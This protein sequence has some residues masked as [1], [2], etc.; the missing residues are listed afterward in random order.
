[1]GLTDIL[2]AA[3]VASHLLGQL[4]FQLQ[5]AQLADIEEGAILGCL[6]KGTFEKQSEKAHGKQILLVA[7]VH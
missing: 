6:A 1:M 2:P 4:E 5:A 3:G 7:G